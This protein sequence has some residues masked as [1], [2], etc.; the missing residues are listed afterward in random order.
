MST[1]VIVKPQARIETPDGPLYATDVDGVRVHG[2]KPMTPKGREAI[3]A[4]IE[5]ARRHLEK[6]K[7]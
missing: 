7:P 1:K 2:S 4:I 5:A 6:I 3:A